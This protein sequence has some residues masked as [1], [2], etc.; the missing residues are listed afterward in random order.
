MTQAKRFRRVVLETALKPFRVL[1]DDAVR[2]TCAELFRQWEP[3]IRHADESAVLL[4][5][6]DG[7]EILTYRGALE[8][9][10]EWARYI[11]FA[12]TQY[13]HAYEAPGCRDYRKAVPFIENPPRMTYG[14]L[15]AIIA[16]LREVGSEVTGKPVSVGATFDPGPEFADSPWRYEHHPEV[17]VRSPKGLRALFLCAQS[18]LNGDSQPYAGFPDGPLD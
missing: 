8:D 6:A 5:T 16:A 3:L 4:W 9:E 10:F 17:F 11:G 2:A 18:T 7:S 15:K 13:P 12:N 14:S 1:T